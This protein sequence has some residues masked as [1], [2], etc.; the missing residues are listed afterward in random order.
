MRLRD[1]TMPHIGVITM[2]KFSMNIAGCI[3]ARK[4]LMKEGLLNKCG[5]SD[6]DGITFVHCANELYEQHRSSPY[7]AFAEIHCLL[8][9]I[10]ANMKEEGYNITSLEYLD[11]KIG[12]MV[13]G[14]TD[15]I[16]K[17]GDKDGN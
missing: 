15:I 1:G 13:S 14:F 4:W 17:L 3:E 8:H 12:D 7:F 5:P 2:P 16:V 6:C 11:E 10:T 9:D